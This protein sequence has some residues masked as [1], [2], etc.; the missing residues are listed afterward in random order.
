MTFENL[1]FNTT[2]NGDNRWVVLPMTDN[3]KGILEFDALNSTN[4]Q[5][6]PGNFQFGVA[7]ITGAN[8]MTTFELIE[9]QDIYYASSGGAL[10]YTHHVIDYSAY[11]GTGQYIVI[12][13]SG[14]VSRQVRIDNVSYVSACLSQSVTAVAQ[15][16]NLQLDATGNASIVVADVDN[17][18]TSECGTP[19]LSIDVNDFNCDNVGPNTVT[20]T[21][22]D[23]NGNVETATATVT[24]LAAVADESVLATV[25][26]VCDGNA[27]TITTGSSVVGVE[28]FLRDDADDTVLDGPIIGTGSG[29]SFST[30]ALSTST[31]FNVLGETPDF[32]PTALS[33]DGVNDYLDLGTDN[34]GITTG[35]TISMWI[36]TSA[37]GVVQYIAGKYNGANGFLLYMNTAGKLVIDGRD[38][39]GVYKSSGASL[40]SINDGQWHYISGVIDVSIGYWGVAIDGTA[41]TA[42]ILATGVTLASPSPLTVGTYT[43]NYATATI[44][45]VSIWDFGQGDAQ[46]QN[47]MNNCMNGAESGVVGLFHLDEGAGTVATDV[48][49]TAINASLTNMAAAAWVAGSPDLCTVQSATSCDREMTQLVTIS[50]ATAYNQSEAASICEGEDYTFPDGSVQTINSQVV[51]TS[52]FQTVV[53]GCDSLIETTVDINPTFD[54][55]ETVSVCEGDSHTFPDGSTQNNITSQVVYISDLNTVTFAC[56]SAI[57]TTVNVTTI[58]NSTSLNGNTITAAQSG[59]TY[60]WLDCD[61]GNVFIPGETGQT[62]TGGNGNYAVEI[63]N[64]TCV[65]TSACTMIITVGIDQANNSDFNIYPNPAKDIITIKGLKGAFMVDI[66]NAVGEVVL[67]DNRSTINVEDLANGPYLVRIR[68]NGGVLNGRFSKL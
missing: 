32:V 27:T 56:D 15:D 68:S 37:S 21:A 28:Y 44:D 53:S 23:G 25:S 3:C 48:S 26:E 47:S 50:I 9:A 39:T 34:R 41:E 13:M 30:G 29:L 7:T 16:F 1:I 65:D 12:W 36:K 46:I 19:T 10:I 4:S 5:A 60:R 51:H 2:G 17:G 52:S 57:E 35:M 55:T 67:T 11:T 38:G 43:T 18:S 62:F 33:L 54:M 24:V 61:N 6:G 8:A 58:D 59:A 31:T 20:L 22:D 45:M 64:G 66:L 49:G 40:T 42:A 63:T 14:A